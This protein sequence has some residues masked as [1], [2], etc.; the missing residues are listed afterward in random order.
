M[1]RVKIGR[2]F[3]SIYLRFSLPVLLLLDSSQSHHVAHLCF[4]VFV[5]E[6]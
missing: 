5:L 3:N 1:C 6:V 2:L 4:Q